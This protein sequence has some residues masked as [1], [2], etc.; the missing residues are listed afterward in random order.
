MKMLA[1][2][3]LAVTL[4]L[5]AGSACRPAPPP[6][7]AEADSAASAGPPLEAP[8]ELHLGR[9]I[10]GTK[11]GGALLI[12]ATKPVRILS[13]ESSCE[14][15]TASALELPRDLRAGET[16]AVQIEVDLSKVGGAQGG[17]VTIS[18]KIQN[19]RLQAECFNNCRFVFGASI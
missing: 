5:F 1:P 4:V 11:V 9:A 12:R 2:L 10:A 7:D 6:P 16:L 13:V 14:C 17:F 15:T 19:V 3:G 18:Q 8:A